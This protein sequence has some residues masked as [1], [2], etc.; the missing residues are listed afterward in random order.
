MDQGIAINIGR[1][2]FQTLIGAW[3]GSGTQPRY[4]APGDPWVE[5]VK[6]LRLTSG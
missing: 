5:I 1:I 3:R 4:E 6:T 2:P